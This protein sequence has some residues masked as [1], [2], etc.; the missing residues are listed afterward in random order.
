MSFCKSPLVLPVILLHLLPCLM[1]IVSLNVFSSGEPKNSGK[2][3]V[4]KAMKDIELWPAS[5]DTITAH[6]SVIY[7]ILLVGEENFSSLPI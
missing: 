5:H 1:Y 7:S 3:L 6:K 2:D 4:E